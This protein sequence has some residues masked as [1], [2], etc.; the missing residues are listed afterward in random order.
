[1]LIT[2]L[3]FFGLKHTGQFKVQDA[4]GG[5]VFP[6]GNYHQVSL[7]NNTYIFPHKDYLVISLVETTSSTFEHLT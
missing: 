4:F 1:M 7:Q 6:C 2:F 5:S 3:N